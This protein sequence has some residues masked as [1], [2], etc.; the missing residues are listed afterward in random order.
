VNRPGRPGNAAI[1]FV[2]GAVAF[3]VGV[4]IVRAIRPALLMDPDPSWIVARFLLWL[5]VLAGTASAGGLA[6]AGFLSWSRSSLGKAEPGPLPLRPGTTAIVCGSALLAGLFLRLVWIQSLPIP[7]LG[8]EISLIGPSLGLTGQWR[9]FANSIR[10][11][12]YGAPDAHEMIGVLYLRMFRES[13]GVFG[14]TVLGVRFIS[15]AGG[16]LSLVTGTLLA[17]ALLP[18]GGAALTAVVLAGLRWHLILSRIGWH[19]VILVP[20]VDLATLAVIA[21][22][23]RQRPAVAALAG[24]LLGL[25]AHFYLAAWIAGA[26][27][28]GFCALPRAPRETARKRVQRLAFCAAG[29]LVVAAPLFLF[30]EGRSVG[31]FG[32]A[33]RHSVIAE[34]RY[35]RSLLPP[36]SVAAESL[37]AP[38]LLPDPEGWHDLPGRS[39]LGWIIGIPVAVAFARALASPRAELSGLLLVQAGLALVGAV[40]GGQAG[41]PNGFRFGYLTTL[42]AVAAASGFLQIVRWAPIAGR[43]AAAIAVIG[44]AAAS[45]AAG[46]RDAILRW[47]EHRATF[48]CFGGEDMLIGRA[49]ARWEKYGFVRVAPGLGR[50]E[51]NIDTVRRYRLSPPGASGRAAPSEPVVLR[52]SRVFRIADPRTR[53]GEGERRVET[54]RDGF[55]LDWA[56]VIG[57]LR[58]RT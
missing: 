1:F 49:A 53:P 41:H 44:L 46:A 18:G 50:A 45:G 28:L 20:L 17:R 22:R 25:G 8:D 30:R 4:Q 35:A 37:V 36:F 7:F 34:V 9:D 52:N 32:R 2:G 26:A 13:L 40:A 19:S 47:P 51:A 38:W 21:S 11:V 39:R 3:V 27:V 29:F 24:A 6:A 31:Y 15:F 14:A 33:S 56:V 10:P 16:A 23:R 42:T 48:Y 55:G 5:G 12:P 54:V 58:S 43:R 57:R